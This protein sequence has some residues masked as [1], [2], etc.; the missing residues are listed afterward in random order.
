MEK[1][2]ACTLLLTKLEGMQ[3]SRTL[4]PSS[5]GMIQTVIKECG[6]KEIFWLSNKDITPQ[7]A[8]VLYHAARN[9]RM[10]LEKMHEKFVHAV[11]LHE[12]P[13]VV[14]DALVVFPELSEMCNIMDSMQKTEI[15]PP[16]LEYVR[17]HIRTLRNAAERVQML[18]ST[19][20]EM[21]VVDKKKFAKEFGDIAE[22][23][24]SNL[25]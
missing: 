2:D 3:A 10:V 12:N 13:K 24:R 22:D 6:E 9:A 25:V 14:D 19:E 5:I 20:E 8:F 21:K 23:L 17:R 4:D 7:A 1:N 15:K 16:V 11:E 18:P